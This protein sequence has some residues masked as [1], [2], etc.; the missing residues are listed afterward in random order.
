[1][2]AALQSWSVAR[3]SKGIPGNVTLD[4][5]RVLRLGGSAAS[6]QLSPRESS[7]LVQHEL[8]LE[9][10]TASKARLS[11]T[12]SSLEAPS[13]KRF[14]APQR[15]EVSARVLR[16]AA[17]SKGAPPDVVAD[18]LALPE[19]AGIDGDT[20]W[21]SIGLSLRSGRDVTAWLARL[22]EFT[23]IA[24]D[25]LEAARRFHN[26]R[27]YSRIPPRRRPRRDAPEPTHA[28]PRLRDGV[29]HPR[30]RRARTV[31][32]GAVRALLFAEERPFL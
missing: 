16:L 21:P 27:S 12:A 31:A 7:A 25:E 30:R 29:R 4:S 8:R 28:R 5:A 1:M 15:T 22:K 6:E 11:P 2:D 19:G 13:P 32:G 9:R 18:A 26:P 17:A 3:T 14:A 24:E 10:G 20:I 23:S